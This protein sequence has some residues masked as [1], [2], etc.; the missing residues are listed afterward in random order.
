L[1]SIEFGHYEQILRC[2]F[3]RKADH[4]IKRGTEQLLER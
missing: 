1:A 4:V 3:S 2:K